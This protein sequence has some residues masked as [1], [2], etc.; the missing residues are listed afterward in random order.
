VIFNALLTGQFNVLRDALWHLIL[1]CVAVGTIPLA[2]IAR[3]TRSSMLE[4]LGQD[5]VR[6]ARAKGLR[7]RT[8][9]MKHAFRNAL[10]PIVTI[11][12]LS[13]GGL[14]SGAV[15]TETVFALP[16]VGTQLVSAILARDYPVVQAFTVVIAVMFVLV[17]LV[18]DLSYAYLYPR[19]LLS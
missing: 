15:L 4:V 12:G 2:I 5:Y 19:I 8:I 11:V 6:T 3:M 18:V 7:E 13:F 16:G 17:N 14:M 9:V 1:P 10:L